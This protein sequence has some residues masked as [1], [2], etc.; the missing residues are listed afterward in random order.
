MERVRIVRVLYIAVCMG[1]GGALAVADADA[2]AVSINGYGTLGVVHSSDD[3]ADY[4][5][6]IFR[7]NGAGHTRAW[8]ADIDTRLGIQ[9]TADVTSKLSAVFQFVAE[10]RYDNSYRPTT[11]WANLIYHFTPDF[12]VRVGRFVQPTFL[13]ADSRK[14]AYTYPWVR[15]PTEVYGLVPVSH[16]DGV[17][18][19]YRMQFGGLIQTLEA[20]YGNRD[21]RSP[22]RL[23]GEESKARNTFSAMSTTEYGATTLRISYHQT[24]LTVVDLVSLF[25]AF[26]E[27]GPEGIAIADRYGVDDERV[28]FVGVG[29]NYDPGDWFA[30]GE[31][32][33]V[34]YH[35]V[36]GKSTGWYLSSGYR[37]GSLTPFASFARLNYTD[38]IS[39]PGL[40]VSS[41]P[42]ALIGPATGLNAA[43][44]GIL[45][46]AAGQKTM[47]VGLRWDFLRNVALKVQVEHVDR[48]DGSPGTFGNVQP[49]FEPGGDADLFSASINVVF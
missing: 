43:L 15:P 37:F 21:I 14:V 9:V 5:A 42:P 34:D 18:L 25:D 35:N 11:E 36:F 13:F 17:D 31:W 26:R 16:N 19:S 33:A 12:S 38:M 8:S 32:G 45:G 29:V 49:G 30:I 47:A 1:S 24:Q 28:E 6:D 4:L 44:N 48:D 20:S 22:D 2:P 41:L 10:Q 46:G 3:K 7:P 23:G 40:T 39:D 27:F